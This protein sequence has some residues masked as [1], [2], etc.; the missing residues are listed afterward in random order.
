LAGD[1]FTLVVNDLPGN[2]QLAT[3]ASE[4]GAM[5]LPLDVSDRS[6]VFEAISRIEVE[7]EPVGVLVANHAWMEMAPFLEQPADGWWR[8]IDVNVSGTLWLVQAVLSGMR[9]LGGGRIVI[10]A[11]EAGVVGMRNASG[12]SASKA[13]L[14]TLAKSLARELAPEGI[15]TNAVAPSYIDTPQLQVD[16]SD[17]GL[18]LEEMKSHYARGVPL[19]RIASPEEIAAA[20]RY[21]LS[22]ES[23]AVVGQVIQP[24]GGTTRARA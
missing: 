5:P 4:T 14:I 11:S 10:I 3:V 8:H 24:N 17:A 23:E 1:G 18:S 7:V 20:V 16:A 12:Y 22:P 13:G 9:R 21:L 19:G 2:E 15:I 6:A